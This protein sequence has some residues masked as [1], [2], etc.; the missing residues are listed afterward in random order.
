MSDANFF[1]FSAAIDAANRWSDRPFGSS[2]AWFLASG[3]RFFIPY[4]S[5]VTTGKAFDDVED[6]LVLPFE[7]TC[8][9]SETHLNYNLAQK[10][11]TITIAIDADSEVGRQVTSKAGHAPVGEDWYV[12]ISLAKMPGCDWAPA[13]PVTIVS[14]A[15]E[16]PSG[17]LS[18]HQFA[19]ADDFYTRRISAGQSHDQIIRESANDVHVITE[20]C[21]LLGLNN[22]SASKLLPPKGA[23]RARAAKHKTPLYDYHVLV[24]DGETWSHERSDA[25]TSGLGVR[26]HLRR[27]H[28]RRLADGR[29]VWVR[30][31]YV[32][33]QVD[34]FVAK[35]YKVEVVA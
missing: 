32:H 19:T 17:K 12:M 33:G 24:V 26:S 9:L 7:V 35:D 20:L 4:G 22:T 30:A 29:R 15:N 14:K 28:V 3:Q 21:V 31:T 10:V 23:V 27:G 16:G 25:P 34:G 8:I 13:A 11:Q 1:A 5:D 2:V 18:L 6:L